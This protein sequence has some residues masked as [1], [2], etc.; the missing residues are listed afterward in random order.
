MAISAPA[1]RG[2]ATRAGDKAIL[3]FV[4][5]GE[6]P[7]VE[8]AGAGCYVALHRETLDQMVEE[9]RR[10]PVSAVVVS[11]S[12]YQQQDAPAI[13]RLVRE[14][15]AVP[16]VA[17]LTATESRA[18]QALLSMGQQGVRTLVDAREPAGWRDLRT[19]VARED[20][21]AIE[22]IAKA[23]IL[24]D[25]P[26]ATLTS[27]RFITALFD[28][29]HTCTTVRDFARRQGV[30]P[31]TF[32]TR[33]FRAGLPPAKRYLSFARLVRAASLFE[34]PGLSITQVALQL[35][36][37]SP[38]AF[39]RHLHIVLGHGAAEFRRRYTG[40]G[41]LDHMRRELI[42]PHREALATFDPY[43]APPQWLA[44]RRARLGCVG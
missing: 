36:Y 42:V 2:T 43:H 20:P 26:H 15:P 28:A 29:P 18:T 6:R 14:F 30:T 13:A 37:S 1:S 34:N 32:M 23:R 40:E 22:T 31:T 33:F 12:R 35:E 3:T 21:R 24:E 4:T 5:P 44:L 16:A 9:M 41:M 27:R 19:L 8:A 39:S 17:L 11:V 25:L 38:Q 7:R 10:R